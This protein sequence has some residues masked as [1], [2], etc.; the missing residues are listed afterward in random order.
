MAKINCTMDKAKIV[1]NYIFTV[2]LEFNKQNR[3][4]EEGIF[5]MGFFF[6]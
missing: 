1:T 4:K 5:W 2:I 6:F 3:R